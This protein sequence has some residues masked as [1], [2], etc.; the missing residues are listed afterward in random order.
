[1]CQLRAQPQS[2]LLS[3]FHP[4]FFAS[5]PTPLAT[6]FFLASPPSPLTLPS[7]SPNRHTLTAW[8]TDGTGALG[9]GL[10]A[11][12]PTGT[13][14]YNFYQR[15]LSSSATS[16]SFSGVQCASTRCCSIIFC[17]SANSFGC[18]GLSVSQAINQGG[19]GS[20]AAGII[21]AIVIGVL[22]VLCAAGFFARRRYYSRAFWR[23]RVTFVQ[24]LVTYLSV[25]P[26]RAASPR[27]HSRHATCT[28]RPPLPHTP[29]FPRARSPDHHVRQ[30]RLRQHH[31]CD[32]SR[33]SAAAAA[34][35][36]CPA[37]RGLP[38]A[39]RPNVLS[40]GPLHVPA[41]AAAR[42]PAAA[43]VPAAAARIPT[44]A[45][46]ARVRLPPGARARV[47][48]ALPCGSLPPAAAARPRVS[49]PESQRTARQNCNGLFFSHA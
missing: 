4:V 30:P 38:A 5:P 24:C 44:A 22:V 14:S 28:P 35:F 48:G 27:P 2:A 8:V 37:E 26:P 6:L 29:A 11:T 20:L 42:V 25:A 1:V 21:V 34:R 16:I 10:P 15:V 13:F 47:C 9:C 36:F 33:V 7:R 45:A 19:P 40:A 41:A 39:A 17:T 43:S 49:T 32:E 31:D 46:A 12:N 18:Y 23:L 3:G